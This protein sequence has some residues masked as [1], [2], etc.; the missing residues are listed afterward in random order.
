MNHFRKFFY[1]VAVLSIALTLGSA[2]QAQQSAFSVDSMNKIGGLIVGMG[3]D[4]VGS[5]DNQGIVA[6]FFKWQFDGEERYIKLMGT[7]LT[8][9]ALDNSNFELGPV[10]NF[11]FGRD[12]DVDDDVVKNMAE[13][14]DTVELGIYGAYI[15][16]DQ[17]NPKRRLITSAEVLFDVGDEYEGW[18]ATVDVKYWYPVNKEIDLMIGLGT[19]YGNSDYMNTYFGVSSA[20]EA[21]TGLSQF[22]AGSGFQDIHI[23]VVIMYHYSMNWHFVG[24]LKYLGLLGDASDSPVVDDRGDSSQL[25]AGV[26]VGYSW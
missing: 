25:I 9:N 22:N 26:R 5:D 1:V 15:W 14:D 6:P 3:P 19:T 21:V 7:E 20:D 8:F 13:I 2:A 4:Y 12:D 24:G 16:R 23:P 10:L 17:A 11:R 18:L